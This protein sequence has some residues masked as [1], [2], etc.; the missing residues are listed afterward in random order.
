[1]IQPVI[2]LGEDGAITIDENKEIIHSPSLKVDFQD[3]IGA[4]DALAAG[5]IAGFLMDY[6]HQLALKIGDLCNSSHGPILLQ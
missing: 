1:M 3:S 4:G 2:T 5:Y 6:S